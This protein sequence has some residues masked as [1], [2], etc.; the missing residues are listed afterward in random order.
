M[1]KGLPL[2]VCVCIHIDMVMIMPKFRENEGGIHDTM[3]GDSNWGQ[4]IV[5]I[6]ASILLWADIGHCEKLRAPQVV[7]LR[8]GAYGRRSPPVL[9][10]LV[11]SQQQCLDKSR[12][13]Y[14]LCAKKGGAPRLYRSSRILLVLGLTALTCYRKIAN[15]IF[16]QNNKREARFKT[17]LHHLSPLTG[18]TRTTNSWWWGSNTTFQLRGCYHMMF[19]SFFQQNRKVNRNKWT[20]YYTLIE[21]TLRW[22]VYI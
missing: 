7:I 6:S 21:M 13:R 3:N 22:Y 11:V 19:P 9:F 20:E 16:C 17:T 10:F 5:K 8:A 4:G 15:F 14:G 12:K 18:F 2:C 1:S